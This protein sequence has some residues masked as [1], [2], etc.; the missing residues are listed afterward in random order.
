[1]LKCPGNLPSIWHLTYCSLLPYFFL[2]S[3]CR[4]DLHFNK[5]DLQR[6]LHFFQRNSFNLNLDSLSNEE[7]KRHINHRI[8]D[9]RNSHFS[10]IQFT[11]VCSLPYIIIY[12]TYIEQ[13]D[14]CQFSEEIMETKRNSNGKNFNI[15]EVS[16]RIT[17][18]IRFLDSIIY[19][20]PGW[21]SPTDSDVNRNICW[22]SIS[23]I[24]LVLCPFV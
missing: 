24:P 14:S 21:P 9:S 11:F 3:L 16:N 19:Y 13:D 20:S 6:V 7:Q 18:N 5:R 12:F 10:H 15:H 4:F 8:A 17:E 1:M 2:S 23:Y 22:S